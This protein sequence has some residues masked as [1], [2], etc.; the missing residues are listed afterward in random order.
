MRDLL[1][2]AAVQQNIIWEKSEANRDAL[3]QI[4]AAQKGN[5][6]IV[7]LPEMFTTGFSMSPKSLAEPEEGETLKWMKQVATSGS[8]ALCGSIIVESNARYYNRFYFVEP[9]GRVSWYNKR[10]LFRMGDEH[11]HYAP[12]NERKIISYL[13]WRIMP[14]ICY[15][16]R[17]PVFSRNR[18]DYDLLIYVANFPASRRGVWNTLLP[19]R[20]IENQCYVVAV[21]R[22]G[23]DGVGLDY[24]GDSAI[25]N[26]RGNAMVRAAENKEVVVMAEVSLSELNSFRERFPVW[27]DADDFTIKL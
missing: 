16:L 13:G 27:L 23:T 11:N 18:N 4:L 3:E 26:P 14:Q 22:V 25:Y 17:F 5:A 2:V 20:A 10:H 12:G 6:D 15:D 24:S 7:I 19:A 1:R 9:S 8:F 21:N